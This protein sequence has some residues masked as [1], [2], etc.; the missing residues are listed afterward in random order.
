M[1]ANIPFLLVGLAS[2]GLLQ[3]L[4]RIIQ[5]LLYIDYLAVAF[6]WRII[7][8]IQGFIQGVLYTIS[9]PIRYVKHL[10]N[11]CGAFSKIVI[12]IPT[13]IP[14]MLR[15][16]NDWLL[17]VLQDCCHPVDSLSNF[18]QLQFCAVVILMI[19]VTL[20]VLA[21][22]RYFH[23]TRAKELTK[24]IRVNEVVWRGSVGVFVGVFFGMKVLELNPWGKLTWI[25]SRT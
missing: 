17:H 15:P 23:P 20:A 9:A 13:L 14:N 8:L 7:H 24:A 11:L 22:L 3:T 6:T 12:T 18:T 25:V 2:L 16:V 5:S 19:D 10:Y 21:L 1:V 4:F